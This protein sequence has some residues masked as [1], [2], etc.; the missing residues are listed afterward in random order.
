MPLTLD[1]AH[2]MYRWDAIPPPMAPP[3]DL[4]EFIPFPGR[5]DYFRLDYEATGKH[6]TPGKYSDYHVSN[7]ELF[8]AYSA[9]TGA[10]DHW[11]Y[12]TGCADWLRC[13]HPHPRWVWKAAG[14]VK[15]PDTDYNADLPAGWC[16]ALWPGAFCRRHARHPCFPRLWDDQITPTAA[17]TCV[18]TATMA[19]R[20]CYFL[21]GCTPWAPGS[22]LGDDLQWYMPA[23]MLATYDP[24]YPPAVGPDG[25][26]IPQHQLLANRAAWLPRP[27][28]NLLPGRVHRPIAVTRGKERAGPYQFQ[29]VPGLPPWCSPFGH[30]VNTEHRARARGPVFQHEAPAAMDPGAPADVPARRVTTARRRA[31]TPAPRRRQPDPPMPPPMPPHAPGRPGSSDRP[32]DL[33]QPAA[34]P[35]AQQPVRPPVM[36]DRWTPDPT[37]AAAT[38]ST[39]APADFLMD[40]GSSTC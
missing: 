20:P 4:E 22:V 18:H 33:P 38:N 17:E 24:E 3:P 37:A 2:S 8:P 23:H 10:C 12:G 13:E 34:P 30:A 32:N 16:D 19:G 31:G 39:T 36:L 40:E 35:A 6:R 15:I 26:L 5:L 28:T 29:P 1:V 14:N 27:D 9:A 25:A 7:T 11:Y 21:H